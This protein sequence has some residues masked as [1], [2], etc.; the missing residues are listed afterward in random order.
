MQP[1]CLGRDPPTHTP[2][3]GFAPSV[4]LA[5]PALPSPELQDQAQR[6]RLVRS[7]VHTLP[8]PNHD[9]MRLLFQHLCR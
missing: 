3:P 8:T 4:P 9:T 5:E 1:A 2:T 7:L 6:S